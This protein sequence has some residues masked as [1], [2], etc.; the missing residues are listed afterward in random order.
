[1]RAKDVIASHPHVC[2]APL[3]RERRGNGSIEIGTVLIPYTDGNAELGIEIVTDGS[4]NLVAHITHP[5]EMR[6]QVGLHH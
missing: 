2:S 3:T 6:G 4:A 5:I 1:M